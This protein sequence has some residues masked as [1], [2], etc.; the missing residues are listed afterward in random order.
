MKKLYMALLGAAMAATSLTA[1][2]FD[3]E[4]ELDA[5]PWYPTSVLAP[6]PLK[7]QVIFI[8]GV[9]DVQTTATY[10][11][12]AGT[13]KA[14]QWHDFI[15]FTAANDDDKAKI[16]EIYGWVS[17]NHEMILADD[18]I[19]DGGGMTTF[20]VTKNSDGT[21]TVIDQT[22]D[23]GRSG[24]FF[25]VD[26]V[27]T[28]GET[29]MNC[30]GI[31]APDGRIWTAEEW[32]QSSL[33][34]D[35]RDAEDFVIGTTTPAGFPGY[36]GE[37]LERVANLNYMVEIDP[38]QAKAIRKQYNWGRQPFEGGAISQDMTTAYLGADNT[39]GLFTKFVADTP[40]DFT[41]GKTY[42]YKQDEN[43][44]S[45]S[46]V[47][48]DMTDFNNV[49]NFQ[50]TGFTSGGT[51]FN[52]LEWVTMDPATGK[53]YMTETGRD[54]PGSRLNNAIT[55]G[56]NIAYHHYLR[57]QEQGVTGGPTDGEYWDY[58]GRVLEYDPA[59]NEVKPYL[60]G[61]PFW[62]DLGDEWKD[63]PY[64]PYPEKHLSNPDGLTI[65]T[66]NGKSVM[67]ICEDLNGSSYGRVRPGVDNRTC[68]LWVLDMDKEISID[69]L[70]R[71]GIVPV[72]AEVT[73]ACP[74]PDG[75]SLLVNSQH[76]KSYN[77]Y[78][79]NNSLTFVL[80]GWQD[81]ISSIQEDPGL[82]YDDPN[83]FGIYP[84][85]T[86]REIRFNE[87]TDAAL[88]DINGKR[89]KVVM[90]SDVMDVRE[91]ERGTYFIKNADGDVQKLIIE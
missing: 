77:E 18:M 7:Y 55:A 87:V 35:F 64:V 70:V 84:N 20:A 52:R 42:V 49:P 68:E 28:V 40:G 39:P 12:P 60:E 3:L 63:A 36:N 74:T 8:G 85:P 69:N 21:L 11:S 19:G 58:Y 90:N 27:N 73:G 47:E 71:V 13:T 43:S 1:S 31:N 72:G 14:K 24:K 22:L 17:V 81:F 59:T 89:L 83:T 61:G 56:G 51:G 78:P 9:D 76:P 88:Y 53:V 46:W 37:T 23:D 26:F 75:N 82:Q 86:S 57:A 79:Y 66:V 38:R 54:N 45:G 4:L 62:N 50:A 41:S 91:F 29:G 48:I 65:M 6:S 10:D 25:N 80:T 44:Y 34:D 67:V 16:P 5:Y 33:D 30:G 32:F 15:G 2:E